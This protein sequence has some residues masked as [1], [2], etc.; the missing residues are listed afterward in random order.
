MRL[1]TR[2]ARERTV[3]L[4]AR[5]RSWLLHAYL[6]VPFDLIPVFIPVIG[7]AD[8][9]IIVAAVLRSVVKRAGREVVEHHWPGT[10]HGLAALTG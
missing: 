3:P 1:V 10:L 2:L 9:A 4:G 7:Y 5:I 8:D 6:S